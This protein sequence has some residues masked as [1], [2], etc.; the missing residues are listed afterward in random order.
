[1]PQ[2]QHLLYCLWLPLLYQPVAAP[3]VR[4]VAAALST[5]RYPAFNIA[6][7]REQTATTP[8]RAAAADAAA[9]TIAHVGTAQRLLRLPYPLL[10][11][12][13]STPGPL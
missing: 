10:P 6:C 2:A 5:Q 13:P 7:S 11:T 3:P 12:C 8:V 1:M 9:V 4:P